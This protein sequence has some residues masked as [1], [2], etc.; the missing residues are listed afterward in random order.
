[1]EKEQKKISTNGMAVLTSTSKQTKN[2]GNKKTSN[3][4][5]TIKYEVFFFL[6]HKF[7]FL[8]DSYKDHVQQNSR[9]DL[10]TV[11]K[12]SIL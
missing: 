7:S 2:L 1:M 11:V 3:K 6:L 12:T 4:I 9:L 10:Y 5:Q 8:F